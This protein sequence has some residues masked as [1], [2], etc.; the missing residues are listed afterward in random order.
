MRKDKKELIPMQDCGAEG[1]LTVF[2]V[3]SDYNFNAKHS[4]YKLHIQVL[5]S[6]M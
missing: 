6:N 4:I 5:N 3:C 1:K 2:S